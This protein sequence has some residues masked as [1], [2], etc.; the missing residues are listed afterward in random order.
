MLLLRTR[1]LCYGRNSEFACDPKDYLK[2]SS[3]VLN[4]NKNVLG[5]SEVSMASG[6]S[7]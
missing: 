6:V 4:F 5:L 7:N 3:I 2:G 1:F